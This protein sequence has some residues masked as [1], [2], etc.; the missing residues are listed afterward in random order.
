MKGGK[1]PP[2]SIIRFDWLDSLF[3]NNIRFVSRYHT[4][5]PAGFAHQ[6]NLIDYSPNFGLFKIHN[7]RKM[8]Y[9]RWL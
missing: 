2:D 7:N 3:I 6:G 4:I 5:I 1:K 8:G 9:N